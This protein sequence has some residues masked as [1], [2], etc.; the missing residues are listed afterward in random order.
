MFDLSGQVALVT[1]SSRG[2]GLE[3]ARS[4]A[5]QGATVV[6]NGR[7]ASALNA[8][9]QSL[10]ADGLKADTAVFDIA[11]VAQSTQA[12]DALVQKHGRLDIFFANAAIQHREPLLSFPQQ[13]FEQVVFA[14]LTA[15]WALGRHVAAAMVKTGYGRIVFT[16][17]ITAIQ[18]K[19]GI[20]A[21]T[22]AKAAIHGL[23]RQWAAE[24]G[25]T[26]VTVNAVA[27]GYIQTELTR[28]LWNDP[29]FT[30]WLGTRVPQ[31]RWGTPQDIA[32]AVV[33]LASRESGFMTGQVL[34]ID[35]GLTACM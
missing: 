23:V 29:D 7:T 6:L 17:S 34:A 20:T 28:N 9:A 2:I 21:Y 35:G 26:G 14:D 11:N 30:Q 3:A 4:L 1:G 8:V 25:D 15:Q 10:Q 13:A 33:Y 16:G 32:A 19:Q 18:G 5:L 12:V 31:K 27:P 22:A 24:F